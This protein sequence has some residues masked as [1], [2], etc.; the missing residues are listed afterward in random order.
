[1][2]LI[3][4]FEA[5]S[6]HEDQRHFQ[7]LKWSPYGLQSAGGRMVSKI[8][9]EIGDVPINNTKPMEASGVGKIVPGVNTTPDV[10]P[11]QTEIEAGKFFGKAGVDPTSKTKLKRKPKAL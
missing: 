10:D 2:R 3:E 5:V 1:M 7:Q 11:N 8:Y 9:Q 6:D 4:I